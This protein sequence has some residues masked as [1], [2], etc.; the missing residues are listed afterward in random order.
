MILRAWC[1]WGFLAVLGI[2]AV[3]SAKPHELASEPSVD[4]TATPALTQDYF[5]TDLAKYKMATAVR[6]RDLSTDW[7]GLPIAELIVKSF[8]IAVSAYR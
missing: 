1:V 8:Q 2:A 5:Q 7:P 6:H 4:G 3:G